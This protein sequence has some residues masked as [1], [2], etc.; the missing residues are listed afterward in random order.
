MQVFF[1]Y[2][3]VRPQQKELIRDIVECIDKRKILLA[4]A[5]TGLGKTVSSLAPIISYARKNS[6]KI[7]FITPKV[8][9]HQIVIDTIKEINEKF[10]FGVTA[11]DLVGRK[12]MCLDPFIKNV[13]YGF[14]EACNKK[15]RTHV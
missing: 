15:E 14:Y 1:P 9:Q 13:S 4:H 11:V 8:S 6:K 7:F 12:Q 10:D 3:F 5:P 2:E